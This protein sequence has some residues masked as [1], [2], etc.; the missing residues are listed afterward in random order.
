M[1]VPRPSWELLLTQEKAEELILGPFENWWLLKAMAPEVDTLKDLWAILT[2]MVEPGVETRRPNETEIQEGAKE[3]LDYQC[4]ELCI[5][6]V[7]LS[8]CL[9]L[10]LEFFSVLSFGEGNFSQQGSPGHCR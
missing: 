5:S 10:F 4:F 7:V 6:W 1:L 3:L 8:H 2:D 9:V